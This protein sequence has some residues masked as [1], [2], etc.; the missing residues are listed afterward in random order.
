MNE[1]GSKEREAGIETT[2]EKKKKGKQPKK[3]EITKKR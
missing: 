1:K 3:E 2:K